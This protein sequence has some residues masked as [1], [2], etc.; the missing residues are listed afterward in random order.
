MGW[1][2]RAPVGEA[3]VIGFGELVLIV[4]VLGVIWLVQK[5]MGVS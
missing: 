5:I 2:D 3:I 4:V 1:A